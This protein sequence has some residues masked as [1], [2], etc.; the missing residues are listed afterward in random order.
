MKNIYLSIVIPCYNESENIKRGVL[1]EVE[2][3]MKSKDFGWE[4]IVS[5]TK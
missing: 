4:V 5:M 1:N 2:K 3:F